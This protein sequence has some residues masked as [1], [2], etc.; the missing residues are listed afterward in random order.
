MDEQVALIL[1]AD[2]K[3]YRPYLWK[4]IEE[5]LQKYNEVYKFFYPIIC[6][7]DARTKPPESMNVRSEHIS[8][9]DTGAVLEMAKVAGCSNSLVSPALTYLENPVPT[10]EKFEDNV[11]FVGEF[12]PYLY[13]GNT[14]RLSRAWNN[15][16]WN[17]L[18]DLNTNFKYFYENVFSKPPS[19]VTRE[20]VGAVTKDVMSI[21]LVKE[22]R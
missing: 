19:I 9:R 14:A 6:Y 20:E 13:Y 21:D 8:I 1:H 7:S 5:T 16:P 11:C 4:H 17:P 12:Q 22:I 2:V 18:N 3:I 15:L 10:M